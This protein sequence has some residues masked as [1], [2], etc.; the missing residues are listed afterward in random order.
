MMD[1]DE[2]ENIMVDK[3]EFDGGDDEFGF[4]EYDDD[5]GNKKKKNTMRQSVKDLA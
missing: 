4:D 5:G 2:V 1:D 3:D